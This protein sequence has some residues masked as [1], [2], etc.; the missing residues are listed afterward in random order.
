MCKRNLQ[1]RTRQTYSY[2]WAHIAYCLP[3]WLSSL[4]FL[5]SLVWG[6]FFLKHMHTVGIFWE[7]LYHFLL[8]WMHRTKWSPSQRLWGGNAARKEYLL[9]CGVCHLRDSKKAPACGVY[10]TKI[11]NAMLGW[12]QRQKDGQ[13]DSAGQQMLHLSVPRVLRLLSK[14]LKMKKK[15][16]Q[17]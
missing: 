15:S 1:V 8:P 9:A 17:S 14:T 6:L 5:S 11:E 16:E 2:A 13:S 4:V 10:K 12:T 7:P 3:T